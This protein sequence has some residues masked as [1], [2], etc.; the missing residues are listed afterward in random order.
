[1]DDLDELQ[2]IFG[3]ILKLCHIYLQINRVDQ[4]KDSIH[5]IPF[6]KCFYYRFSILLVHFRSDLSLSQNQ[7][8]Q[9]WLT[10]LNFLHFSN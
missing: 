10:I 6:N 3:N 7:L 5:I 4:V 1:M 8:D 2:Q 9:S